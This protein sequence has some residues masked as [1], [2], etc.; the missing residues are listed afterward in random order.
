M[1][2]V[3]LLQGGVHHIQI[4]GGHAD[5]HVNV[6]VHQLSA[7]GAPEVDLQMAAKSNTSV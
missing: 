2:H 1:L 7:L 5:V 3:T 6:D 4:H